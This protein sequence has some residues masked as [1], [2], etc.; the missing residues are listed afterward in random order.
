[1]VLSSR[2]RLWLVPHAAL[3]TGLVVWGIVR[4]P[5]LP[6]RVP[7]HIGSEGV[8]AWTNRS[9]GSAF[10]PVFLYIGVTVV[11]TACAELTLRVTPTAELPDDA[12]PFGNALVRASLNRPRTRTSALWFARALLALNAC[13]GISFLIFC[14]VMWHSVPER[15]IPGWLFPAGMAPI[16]AGTALMVAAA[17]YDRRAPAAP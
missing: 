5:H 10:W 8:D 17:V 1:M 6:S 4:Y 3:L 2:V 16:V 7:E 12:A 11:L 9:V 13:M 14:A 15:E